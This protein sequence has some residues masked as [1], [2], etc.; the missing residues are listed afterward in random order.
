M[1]RTSHLPWWF[2]QSRFAR[3]LLPC[4]CQSIVS[5]SV[6]TAFFSGIAKS[7]RRCMTNTR[8]QFREALGGYGPSSVL[9][10]VK[11]EAGGLIGVFE[12]LKNLPRGQSER[13]S[14]ATLRPECKYR[15]ICSVSGL[16][17][18]VWYRLQ[19]IARTGRL[20]WPSMIRQDRAGLDQSLVSALRLFVAKHFFLQHRYASLHTDVGS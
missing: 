15:G 2:I 8:I 9:A 4:N 10:C 6:L 18:A 3:A 1:Q 19:G 13:A 14:P 5:T 17:S 7:Y 20:G 11:C 12:G 16:T